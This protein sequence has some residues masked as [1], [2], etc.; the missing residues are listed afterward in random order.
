MNVQLLIYFERK[1]QVFF[2]EKSYLSATFLSFYSKDR[3]LYHLR[4]SLWLIKKPNERSNKRKSVFGFVGFWNLSNWVLNVSIDLGL[5]RRVIW[6]HL[7]RRDLIEYWWDNCVMLIK[8]DEVYL[9]SI[10]VCLDF[11]VCT[12][13]GLKD[14]QI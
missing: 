1:T 6:K 13:M 9:F 5:I 8:Y 3:I 4:Q 7:F 11:L 12:L 2:L 14:V 10:Y